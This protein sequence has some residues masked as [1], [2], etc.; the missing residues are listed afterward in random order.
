MYVF[1]LVG[2]AKLTHIVGS[3]KLESPAY[4]CTGTSGNSSLN[5]A[6]AVYL[7]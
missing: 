5:C 7:K 1:E 6:Y 2:E 4:A 3:L